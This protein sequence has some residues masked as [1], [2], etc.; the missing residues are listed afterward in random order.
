MNKYKRKT[1]WM[2]CTV[3]PSKCCCDVFF[4]WDWLEYRHKLSSETIVKLFSRMPWLWLWLWLWL[5]RSYY[6]YGLSLL[7]WETNYYRKPL[8][9]QVLKTF[10]ILGTRYPTDRSTDWVPRLPIDLHKW[11]NIEKKTFSF[12]NLTHF[13]SLSILTMCDVWWSPFNQHSQTDTIKNFRS[14]RIH[15]K[16]DWFNC[17]YI[18]YVVGYCSNSR[19]IQFNSKREII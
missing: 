10:P 1:K 11:S 5:I 15:E 3:I 8:C 13:L 12:M 17:Y 2:K 4:S 18:E 7:L 16:E 6:I 9:E 14:K 19:T